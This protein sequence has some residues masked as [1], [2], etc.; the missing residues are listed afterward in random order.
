MRL[1]FFGSGE[2]GLPT[3]GHLAQHHEVVGVVTQPDRPAGRHRQPTAT[4]VG[5]FAL[6]HGLSVL[7]AQDAN[8]PQ[9]VA[10][11]ADLAADAAVV[12]AFGQKLGP[13]L[14]EASGR[15]AVNL[16]A[17]LLPQ[18]R[19]AAPINWAIIHGESET[20]VSVISLAQRMDAGL[21]YAQK[22]LAIAPME[23]AG[24]L[25]DRLALLGPQVIMQVL[26]DFARGD[27]R[28]QVQNESQ[29]SRAP[30][31]SRADGW[32]DF[33]ADADKVAARIHGLTPWPGVRVGWHRQGDE[34][35]RELILRRVA[36]QPDLSCFISMR[37]GAR[38]A[39]GLVQE[40]QR[41]AVRDGWVQL[42]QVQL[43]GGKVMPIDEFIRGHPIE[44]GDQLLPASSPR[45]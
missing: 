8:A 42:R 18:Y 31:L 1:L 34:V 41:V 20:G 29:A 39:P 21:I 25:H 6:D 24:E 27:L 33:D 7:K 11:L 4:P 9:I 10:A 17:S 2:F 44:P 14:I 30:K 13:Q 15:L 40:K 22:P 43:P 19:G 45:E 5:Q 38:P 3:L 26:D 28:G 23:T 35:P 16:H 36:P 12:I 32:V 37:P